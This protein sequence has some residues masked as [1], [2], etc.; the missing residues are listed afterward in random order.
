MIIKYNQDADYSKQ[1]FKTQYNKENKED[2][3]LELI[4]SVR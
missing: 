4:I 3:G 2:Y 1:S